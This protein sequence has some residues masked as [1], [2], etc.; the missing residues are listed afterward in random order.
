MHPCVH[1][2]R[3]K[4]AYVDAQWFS[5]GLI[6]LGSKVTAGWAEEFCDA[7]L[8]SN[9]QMNELSVQAAASPRSN[10]S[11]TG[12]ERGLLLWKQ[13]QG[14]TGIVFTIFWKI[15]RVLWSRAVVTTYFRWCK[16]APTVRFY[17]FSS[18]ISSFLV[19]QLPKSK[20]VAW[21]VLLLKSR[22]LWQ[23]IN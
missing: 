8:Q 21:S 4:A 9:R 11:W 6:L 16:S 17:Q 13:Q 7:P 10:P 1:R 20:N 5:S 23:N 12:N 15:E 18:W 2:H 22:Q 19:A 14:E 3:L